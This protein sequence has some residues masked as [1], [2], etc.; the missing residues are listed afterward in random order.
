MGAKSRP[1][2]SMTRNAEDSE[3]ER[4]NRKYGL[5]AVPRTYLSGV[6]CE[7][8]GGKILAGDWPWCKGDP[9]GHVR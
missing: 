8:C 4:L 9:A 3:P 1:H 7:A 6:K 5:W 2:F